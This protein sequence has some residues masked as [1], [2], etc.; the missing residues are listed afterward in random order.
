MNFSRRNQF[1][2]LALIGT[3]CVTTWH[4]LGD[5]PTKLTPDEAAIRQRGKEYVAAVRRGKGEEIASFWTA[6]GD[7]IDASGVAMKGRLLA[8]QAKPPA[9]DREAP[10]LSVTVDL[11]RFITPDV[12]VEDGGLGSSPGAL[13]GSLARRYTAIW[14]RQ[15]GKWLLDGV[16]ESSVP[17][18]THFDRLRELHWMVGDWVS[19]DDGK[20][21]RLSC[22]WTS[23]KNFLLREIDVRLPD[24]EPLHVTQRIGWDARE[25]QIKSWTFDSA[26]GH[27]DGL[28]FYKDEQWI[29]EAQSVLPDGT[30]ATGTHTLVRDGDSAFVWESS[31]GQIDGEPVTEHKVR[32]IRTTSIR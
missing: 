27:G 19:D 10:R 8:Q 2:R 18:A 32:M 16:R 23:E 9:D 30:L 25:K 4:A 12:A 3:A 14:V 24:R 15:K 1:V 29:V 26:G 22:R 13:S 6:D 21:V 11:I 28:W 7:Y 20:T 31:N 5:E 17:E